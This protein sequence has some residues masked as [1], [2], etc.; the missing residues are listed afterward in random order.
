MT[1]NPDDLNAVIK[2]HVLEVISRH[3]NLLHA[4]QALGVNRRT[5]YRW[6]EDWGVS[7]DTARETPH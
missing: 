2:K 7:P 3:A 1:T 4:A 6:L 5:L